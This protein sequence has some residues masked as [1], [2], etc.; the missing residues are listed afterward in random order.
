MESSLRIF[1]KVKSAYAELELSLKRGKG[2]VYKTEKGIYGTTDVD[3]IFKFFQDIHLGRFKNFI[4]LG[5]G[6]GRVV[7]IASLFTKAKGIE[8]DSDLI[9]KAKAIREELHLTCDLIQGDYLKQ[10]ISD[11]D[12]VFMNPDHEFHDIDKKLQSELK[13]TLYI[14]NEIFAPNLLKKGK[15]FWPSQ[16]PIITYTVK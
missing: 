8:F 13:G 4:D 6:D 3:A 15:K 11:Y 9:D 7:L 1:E 2:L 10:D 5:C 14:Y 12:I 16:V